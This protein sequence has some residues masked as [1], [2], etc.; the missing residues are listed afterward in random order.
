[1]GVVTHDH[2]PYAC[3]CVL[4]LVAQRDPNSA[5]TRTMAM[6]FF[7]GVECGHKVTMSCLCKENHTS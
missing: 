6:G 3:A 4:L 2:V 5:C 1:M 7:F